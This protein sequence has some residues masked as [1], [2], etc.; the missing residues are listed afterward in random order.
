VAGVGGVKDCKNHTLSILDREF[1]HFQ[2]SNIEATFLDGV[3]NFTDV[4]VG[5][6]FYHGKGLSFGNLQLASSLDV[7]VF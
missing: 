7:S 2:V 1:C 5:I 6:W 4:V 3:Y